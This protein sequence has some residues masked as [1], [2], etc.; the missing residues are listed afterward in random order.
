ME[1]Q[2][3]RNLLRAIPVAVTAAYT[4]CVNELESTDDSSTENSDESSTKNSESTEEFLPAEEDGWTQTQKEDR[5]YSQLGG[6]DGIYATYKSSPN[7]MISDLLILKIKK[8]YNIQNKARDWKCNVKWQVVLR[9]Q[10]FIVAAGTGTAQK[11]H[12]PEEPPQMTRTPIPETEDEIKKLL[13]NSPK[14]DLQ[15]VNEH[16]VT[17]EDCQDR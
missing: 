7:D 6:E 13:A 16:E 8:A 12:T 9:Y 15:A 17:E 5:D 3:R 14:F 1:Y 4:G 10:E 11:T 2:S